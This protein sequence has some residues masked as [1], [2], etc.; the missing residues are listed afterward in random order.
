MT[1]TASQTGKNIADAL[2]KLQGKLPREIF[3]GQCKVFIFGE[4]LAKKGNSRA[5]G[6][7]TPSSRAKGKS[8]YVCK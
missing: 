6:L 2:S 7:F 5:D 3:W 4:E 1:Y 8:I